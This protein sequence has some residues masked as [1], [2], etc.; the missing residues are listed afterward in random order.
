M[1]MNQRA[2][3]VRIYIP[4]F[5]KRIAKTADRVDQAGTTLSLQFLAEMADV[6]FQHVGVDLAA[7][8]PDPLQ[9]LLA[10][11]HLPGVTQKEQQEPVLL[12]GQ[13]HLMSSPPDLPRG[14]IESQV[15]LI[16][17][18]AYHLAAAPHRSHPRAQ[19]IEREWFGD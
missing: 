7:V 5:L 8:S 2:R 1:S 19:L 13:F 10:C 3:R 18:F 15:G 6:Y 9:E 11:Q 12:H 14:L 17:G 16:K 4:L